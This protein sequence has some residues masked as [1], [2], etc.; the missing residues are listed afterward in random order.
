MVP[1]HMGQLKVNNY[2][3]FK[4]ATPLITPKG[5]IRTLT[6]IQNEIS[7]TQMVYFLLVKD[8]IG[9]SGAWKGNWIWL[10]IYILLTFYM[11]I[12]KLNDVND[13]INIW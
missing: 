12:Y 4:K 6:E 2:I 1:G 11:Y 13:V 7:W 3:M 8:I 5:L 10:N 9:I